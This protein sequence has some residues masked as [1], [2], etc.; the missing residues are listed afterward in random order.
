MNDGRREIMEVCLAKRNS[1]LEEDQRVAQGGSSDAAA[2]L[3]PA[4]ASQP[5]TL[6]VLRTPPKQIPKRVTGNLVALQLLLSRA[7]MEIQMLCS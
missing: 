3:F 2:F 6:T 4:N 5:Q 7:G 1:Q